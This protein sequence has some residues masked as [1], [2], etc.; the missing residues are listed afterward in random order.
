MMFRRRTM[1]QSG[2]LVL[3]LG[4]RHRSFGASI[5]AVRVWPAPDYSRVTIESAGPLK[6]RHA[7][8]PAPPRLVVDIDDLELNAALRELVAKVQPDDPNIAGIRVG[9][10]APGIVRLVVDLKRPI[11]P[12][13]FNLQP[14]AA[15]RDRLVFDLYPTQT[16]DP[17]ETL[18]AER[19]RETRASEPPSPAVGLGPPAPAAPAPVT[20]ADPLGELIARQSGRVIT[21]APAP[22]PGGACTDGCE[23][24][25]TPGTV[26]LRAIQS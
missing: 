26:T 2:A 1:I 5:V 12:Q 11:Q 3:L 18:I 20:T 14:V 13:V 22:A 9:Q 6:A 8:V 10:N 19:M 7:F 17:L 4:V 25:A 15:Y 24:P 23:H 16:P 21:P